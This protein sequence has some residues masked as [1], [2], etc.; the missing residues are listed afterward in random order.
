MAYTKVQTI[1]IIVDSYTELNRNVK[2]CIIRGKRIS[3]RILSK[4]NVFPLAAGKNV[5][6]NIPNADEKLDRICNL[7]QFK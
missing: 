1:T 6:K 4:L 2:V 5:I 3:N 7:G